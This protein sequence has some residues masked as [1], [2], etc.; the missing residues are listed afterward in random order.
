MNTRITVGHIHEETLEQ[1]AMGTL[2]VA[3][4]EPVEEHILIWEHCQDR[5][6]TLDEIVALMRSGLRDLPVHC[7]AAE[8]RIQ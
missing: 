8:I 1:Y 2:A 7:T 6:T 4:S 5:L 3:E